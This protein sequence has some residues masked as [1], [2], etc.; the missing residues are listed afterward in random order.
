MGPGPS[1]CG[2]LAVTPT[3]RLALEALLQ[4]HTPAFA[5]AIRFCSLRVGRRGRGG[6]SRASGGARRARARGRGCGRAAGGEDAA[7]GLEHTRHHC[8]PVRHAR[9]APVRHFPAQARKKSGHA[10]SFGWPRSGPTGVSAGVRGPGI[11]YPRHRWPGNLHLPPGQRPARPGP[12]QARRW[13]RGVSGRL[14]GGAHAHVDAGHA[15]APVP[16]TLSTDMSECIS[17]GRY[18][19]SDPSDSAPRPDAWGARAR[20]RGS[21]RV[22]GGEEAALGLELGVSTAKRLDKR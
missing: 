13:G 12:A 21:R 14:A 10:A 11:P 5:A 4:R 22:A 16:G 20:G 7:L 17:K 19:H 15:P 18:R 1:R 9:R 8:A 2:T 3:L 6:G